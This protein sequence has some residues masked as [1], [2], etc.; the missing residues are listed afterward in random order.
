MTITTPKVTAY[1][2]SFS[3]SIRIFFNA[4]DRLV[5]LHF[6]LKT[7]LQSRKDSISKRQTEAITT[8]ET[9]SPNDNHSINNQWRTLAYYPNVPW[10]ILPALSYSLKSVM[11]GYE[12]SLR[13]LYFSKLVFCGGILFWTGAAEFPFWPLF[14]EGGIGCDGRDGPVQ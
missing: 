3:F 6:A 12:I 1:T 11:K 14:C 7:S 4:T 5:F 8:R 2:P 13:L 9:H 10:P